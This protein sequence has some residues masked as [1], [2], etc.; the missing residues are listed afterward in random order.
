MKKYNVFVKLDA[1]YENV[2]GRDEEDAIEKAIEWFQECEPEVE[3]I[4]VEDDEDE[5]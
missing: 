1:Y 2:K 5:E 4:E 3:V